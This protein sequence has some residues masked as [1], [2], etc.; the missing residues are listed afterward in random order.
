MEIRLNKYLSMAGL[1]SRRKVEGE[2]ILANRVFINN[3]LIKNLSYKVRPQDEIKVD[4]K[5]IEVQK[6]FEYYILNKPKGYV[7]SHKSQKGQKTIYNLLE[8]SMRKINYAGRLDKESHGLIILSN[9]GDFIHRLTHASFGTLKRYRV[10]LD[11]IPSNLARTFEKEGVV[12]EGCLLHV[13]K[14][15]ILSYE[16]KQVEITL[17]EG[18]KRH[19]R[20]MFEGLGIKV[21]DLYRFAIGKMNLDQIHLAEG[22]FLRV[23]ASDF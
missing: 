17:M 6:K 3:V 18:Q 8:P 14:V 7:V 15:K 9:D 11:F 2:Y 21:L 13:S 23:E 1:G 5:K 4:G 12:S 10:S 19:I 22:K 20:R 16:N